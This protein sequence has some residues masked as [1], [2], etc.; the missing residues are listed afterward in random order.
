MLATHDAERLAFSIL[1][2]MIIYAMGFL[3]GLRAE[4]RMQ[5]TERGVRCQLKDWPMPGESVVGF[6]SCNR[7]VGELPQP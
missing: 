3:H 7:A 6:I 5:E 4:E 2:A 1:L